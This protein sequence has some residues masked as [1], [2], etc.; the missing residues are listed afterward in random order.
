MQKTK[1]KTKTKS[2]NAVGVHKLDKKRIQVPIQ[3]VTPLLMEKM[4]PRV[5]RK[6]DKKKSQ[7][8]VKEDTRSEQEKVEDKIHHTEDGNVGFPTAGFKK[9]IVEVA[10]RLDVYKKVVR[11]SIRVL[12]NIVPINYDEKTI[13]EAIGER[14]GRNSSPRLILRPEF[15]NWSCTLDII[16]DAGNISAEQIVNLLNHAGF[17]MGLGG[18]R[19][20]CDGSYG[21]YEVAVDNMEHEQ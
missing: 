19:P 13:N 2:K 4:D 9:G 14:K 7:Q 18:W 3:G 16:Y 8:T 21:Q 10:P 6:Y 12:G 1:T 15:R 20:Q 11:G 5:A 17:H